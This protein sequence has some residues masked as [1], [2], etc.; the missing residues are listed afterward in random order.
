MGTLTGR[1]PPRQQ[2]A[3]MQQQP[4]GQ[5]QGGARQG[6]GQGGKPR[7]QQA[8]LFSAPKRKP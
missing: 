1:K 6:Q 2:N 3:G 7:Q 4:R 5:G 8:A